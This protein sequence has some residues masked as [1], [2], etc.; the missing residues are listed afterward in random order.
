MITKPLVWSRFAVVCHGCNRRFRITKDALAQNREHLIAAQGQEVSDDNSD[1]DVAAQFEFCM[2]CSGGC[3]DTGEF[4]NDN[5]WARRWDPK[6][7]ALDTLARM[8]VASVELNKLSTFAQEFVTQRHLLRL[9]RCA[10]VAEAL[11]DRI[12]GRY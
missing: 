6:G 12:D 4:I 11:R 9:R 3:H 7:W 8:A 2:E 10:F 1:A 5:P